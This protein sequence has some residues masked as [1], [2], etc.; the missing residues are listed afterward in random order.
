MKTNLKKWAAVAV[1]LVLLL[2]GV[3]AWAYLG[4]SVDP[5]V[6]ALESQRQV[7]F[8]GEATDAQRDAFREQVGQLTD[9]QRRQLFE[10]GRPDMQRRMAQRMNELFSLPPDQLRL[11][12]RQR[13]ADIV[14]GRKEREAGGGDRGGRG[15]GGPGGP[16]GAGR[17]GPGGPGGP[18]G[19]RGGGTEAEREA[20]AKQRLDFVDPSTRA[21]F[22]EFRSL[23][24][25]ELKA[26]G[27]DELSGRDMRRLFGPP[28]G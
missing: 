4:D 25:Q 13:A 12:A 7:M 21:Q 26:Q 27:Q 20:R 23:V 9:T 28:R 19:R 1:G 22:S 24:N 18:G 16:D 5:A 8:S 14:A 15:P 11:E 3:G 2:L 10:R 6:A 17:G